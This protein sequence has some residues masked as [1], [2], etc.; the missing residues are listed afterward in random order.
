MVDRWRAMVG[1]LLTAALPRSQ[2]K[3]FKRCIFSKVYF[4]RSTFSKMY[5]QKYTL[6][7]GRL[8]TAVSPRL[9]AT[10]TFETTLGLT[11]S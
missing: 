5:F 2:T 11:V 9:S 1:R 8:L 4:P 3:S 10:T 7:V 6:L